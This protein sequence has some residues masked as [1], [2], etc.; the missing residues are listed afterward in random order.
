MLNTSVIIAQIGL[1]SLELLFVGLY[2]CILQP[3]SIYT[4]VI[5]EG[6]SD[7]K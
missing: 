6:L 1:Y 4:D 2:T 7:E 3:V 5:V